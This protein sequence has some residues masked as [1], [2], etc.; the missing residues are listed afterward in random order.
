MS[1]STSGREDLTT[2]H[3][4]LRVLLP[5]RGFLARIRKLFVEANH[6]PGA[7]PPG[8]IAAEFLGIIDFELASQLRAVGPSL[9]LC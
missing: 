5:A 8:R 9:G 2:E 1:M 4:S 7:E 3:L 6:A